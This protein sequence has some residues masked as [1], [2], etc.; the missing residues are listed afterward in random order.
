MFPFPHSRTVDTPK[1][2]HNSRFSN[3]V[4]R[5]RW[6]TFQKAH[7]DWIC[8]SPVFLLLSFT[9]LAPASVIVRPW[10]KYSYIPCA[11]LYLCWSVRYV[12]YVFLMSFCPFWWFSMLTSG[13][14]RVNF[15]MNHPSFPQCLVCMCVHP[16]L[17]FISSVTVC[18]VFSN[19]FILWPIRRRKCNAKPSGMPFDHACSLEALTETHANATEDTDRLPAIDL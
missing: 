4:N 6:V 13:V 12:G 18:K 14:N 19:P 16:F 1:S 15:L 8:L 3:H 9:L 17:S 5:R 11:R 10:L 2:E 7:R